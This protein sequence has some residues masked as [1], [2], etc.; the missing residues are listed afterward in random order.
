MPYKINV[1]D[2]RMLQLPDILKE[3]GTIIDAARS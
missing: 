2:R 3:S 1:T